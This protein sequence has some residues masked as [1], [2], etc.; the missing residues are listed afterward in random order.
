M[1]TAADQLSKWGNWSAE[2]RN[3]HGKQTSR[4]FPALQLVKTEFIVH[5]SWLP[6][7]PYL[8]ATKNFYTPAIYA[9]GYMVFVF[10]FISSFVRDSVPF[11]KLLKTFMLKFLKW[12][13]SHQPLIRKHSHLDHRYPEGLAFIPWLLT[14]GSLPGVGLEVKI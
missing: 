11:V 13:I 8:M 10:P 7:S 14:S 2:S 12:G 1:N 9:K 5:T 4:F 3:I 6:N